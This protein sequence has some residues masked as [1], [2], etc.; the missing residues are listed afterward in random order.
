MYVVMAAKI[1]GVLTE[2]EDKTTQY[3]T[4]SILLKAVGASNSANNA[5]VPTTYGITVMMTFSYS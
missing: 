5:E 4:T 1:I 2:T 3:T